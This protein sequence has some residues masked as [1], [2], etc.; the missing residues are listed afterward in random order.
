MLENLDPTVDPCENF[1]DFAC[2]G[3]INKTVIPE[4]RSRFD[5][6]NELR[7]DV[8]VQLNGKMIIA[9]CRICCFPFVSQELSTLSQ[10]HVIKL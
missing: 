2:G 9:G 8:D 10:F 3:W 6:I 4:Y 1:Y 7:Y 5:L